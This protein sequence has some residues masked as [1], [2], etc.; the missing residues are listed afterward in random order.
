MKMRFRSVKNHIARPLHRFGYVVAG[1]PQGAGRVIMGGIGAMARVAYFLPGSHLRKTVENFCRV[2][3][4]SDS[5]VLFSRMIDNVERAALYFAS[6]YRYG[7]SELL[8]QTIIDPSVEAGLQRL[9]ASKQGAIVLVPHCAGGALSS[10]KLS[11]LCPTVL[12]VREPKDPDRCQLMLEYLRKLGPELILVRNTP[13]ALVIRNIARALKEGKVV[14]GT[15]DLINLDEYNADTVP[16]RIFDQRI[17]SP[18]WPARLS[19]RFG[20]PIAPIY[21]HMEGRQITLLADEGYVDEDI[22]RSTQRWVSSFEKR[23]REY[24]SDWVFMLDK[25]WA[26]ILGAAAAM[27]KRASISDVKYQET[28]A[29]GQRTSQG[30]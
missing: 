5:R 29:S 21:I 23:F 3:G 26:R 16:T 7:R 18:E 11:T 15:T 20:V 1:L 22:Q 6:L 8:E 4:R 17:L 25:N 24:P 27:P 13:P 30:S 9:K 28:M 19:A 14:V 10:A 12:L 2:T